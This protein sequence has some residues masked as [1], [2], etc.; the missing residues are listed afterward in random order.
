[1]NLRIKEKRAM[2][3]EREERTKKKNL[4]IGMPWTSPG[5]VRVI[6][7]RRVATEDIIRLT[8]DNKRKI[9][10]IPIVP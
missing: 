8:N 7:R 3:E 9:D 1:M 4:A 6:I 10:W 5:C 2:A